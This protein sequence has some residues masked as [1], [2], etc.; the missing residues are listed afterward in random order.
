MAGDAVICHYVKLVSDLD[1]MALRLHA[2]I[3][4]TQ[5]VILKVADFEMVLVV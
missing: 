3:A 2:E 5:Q 1:A 4:S